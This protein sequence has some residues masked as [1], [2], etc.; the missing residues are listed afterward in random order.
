M[1]SAPILVI[2]ANYCCFAFA[3][4]CSLTDAIV[5]AP[6]AAFFTYQFDTPDLLLGI[7]PSVVVLAFHTEL[8]A[9][10]SCM[11]TF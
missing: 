6:A 1:L 10:S 5:S 8:Y 7:S 3:G 9:G 4:R 11:C 2:G